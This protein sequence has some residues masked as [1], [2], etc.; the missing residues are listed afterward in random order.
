MVEVN[1]PYQPLETEATEAEEFCPSPVLP[2]KRKPTRQHPNSKVESEGKNQPALKVA[3]GDPNSVPKPTATE[4]KERPE[5]VR[6]PCDSK[7][8]TLTGRR[9]SAAVEAQ[10]ERS[11]VG[12]TGDTVTQVLE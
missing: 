5:V 4:I 10:A 7:T 2:E 6:D 8:S 3:G 11:P 1:N 9:P 12:V